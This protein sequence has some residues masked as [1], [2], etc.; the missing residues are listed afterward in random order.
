MCTI[1]LIMLVVTVLI[2]TFLLVM[3]DKFALLAAYS[4]RK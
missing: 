4:E 3:F 2:L 1:A